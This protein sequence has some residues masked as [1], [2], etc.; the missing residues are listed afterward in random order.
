ML[1]YDRRD[2]LGLKKLYG[3]FGSCNSC[4]RRSWLCLCFSFWISWPWQLVFNN[5]IEFSIVFLILFINLFELQIEHQAHGAKT[6]DPVM[7]CEKD[8][9]LILKPGQSLSHSNV[10]HET[11]IAFF[12]LSDYQVYLKLKEDWSLNKTKNISCDFTRYFDKHTDDNMELLTIGLVIILTFCLIFYGLIANAKRKE[13][14]TARRVLLVTSHPD[15]ECMFFGPTILSLTKNPAVSL[16]LL[17]MSNGD[18][19]REGQTRKGEL[20]QAC[21]VLGIQEDNITVLR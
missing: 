3:T 18:Y 19:R 12:K 1:D 15:D 9:E 14:K 8:I 7:N 17:C 6:S 5:W 11:E 16:F 21:K 13:I 2:N 10:R 4:F 20:Y